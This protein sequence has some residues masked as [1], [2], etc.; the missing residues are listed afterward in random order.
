MESEAAR[1][2]LRVSLSRL[3]R[4]LADRA[5]HGPRK[6]PLLRT[7]DRAFIALN[8][9]RWAPTDVARFE[10]A[11]LR[12]DSA[13]TAGVAAATAGATESLESAALEAAVSVY[14]GPLLPGYDD[15]WVDAERQRLE[16]RYL[17][18]LRRLVRLCVESR[19]FDRAFDYARRALSVD[20]LRQGAHRDLM[21]LHLLTGRPDAALRQLRD[22]ESLLSRSSSGVALSPAT[23]ALGE[24]IAAAQAAGAQPSS[25]DGAQTN[26]SAVPSL[27][28]Q[29]KVTTPP[30]AS[31]LPTSLTRFFGREAEAAE[32]RTILLGEK[33]APSSSPRRRRL[34]SLTGAGGSGKTRLAEVVAQE[35]W[36][37]GRFAGSVWWLAVSDVSAADSLLT[38]LA[39]RVKDVTAAATE[40]PSAARAVATGGEP[41]TPLKL[42]AAA[43]TAL[44]GSTERSEDSSSVAAFTPSEVT[45][46]LLVL[47][48]AETFLEESA[49]LVRELLHLV[50]SLSCLVTSRV[51]LGLHGEQTF[52]ISMLPCGFDELDST[53]I[54]PE[55]SIA[56]TST[57][58]ALMD[59]PAIQLFA[60]RARLVRPQF[61]LTTQNV[62]VVS[63]LCARLDGS[64][65]AIEL[66]AA[67]TRTMTPAQ[68]LARLN[69]DRF[70]LLV[71][72]GRDASERHRSLWSVIESGERLL[73]AE[74]CRLFRQLS[75]FRGGFTM[76]AALA[77]CGADYSAD[78]LMVLC[79]HSLVLARG[80][81]RF[82]LLES[83]REYA[84]ARLSPG[85]R[86]SVQRRH[87]RFC[88][89]VLDG[90]FRDENSGDRDQSIMSRVSLEV[91]NVR[92]AMER[93]STATDIDDV[94]LGLHLAGVR[95]DHWMASG[96]HLEGRA[97][98][99][100]MLRHA[101]AIEQERPGSLP[102][103][104]VWHRAMM[105]SGTLAAMA[106]D[107]EAAE[108]R[109]ARANAIAE[110]V[111]LPLSYLTA[112][113]VSWGVVHEMRGDLAA[114][115]TTYERCIALCTSDADQTP[116]PTHAVALINL[117][118]IHGRLGDYKLAHV[119]VERAYEIACRLE[120]GPTSHNRKRYTALTLCDMGYAETWLGSYAVARRHL[121]ES[122][123]LLEEAGDLS[124]LLRLRCVEAEWTLQGRKDAAEAAIAFQQILSEA[125]ERCDPALILR[126][127]EGLCRARHRSGQHPRHTGV[128]LGALQALIEHY[129]A[130]FTDFETGL[131]RSVRTD[132]EARFGADTTADA[133]ERGYSLT[134][135]EVITYALQPLPE[136]GR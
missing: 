133:W 98:V 120:S 109:Y 99:D 35:L 55:P 56:A 15:S 4:L 87:A 6:E 49:S 29:D 114:A 46:V 105:G 130:R 28:A 78:L 116:I 9:A 30:T 111:G 2:N 39:K 57:S 79:D 24:Q 72:A 17:S 76:S 58:E 59:L 71:S 38:A 63:A 90:T 18:A 132:L 16:E 53:S 65:L 83:I 103:S 88:L 117:G 21:H 125:W 13:R 129:R 37:T 97:R 48:N 102:L 26:V 126:S 136:P 62:H 25:V 81:G 100:R 64:P 101:D 69:A 44:S 60:D 50:P 80:D 93:S 61:T 8:P 113:L 54:R 66:A 34:V 19:Q 32:I 86:L 131:L 92:A 110:A 82:D 45:G 95:W 77:V 7:G 106:A 14:G 12:A 127:L 27:T 40:A 104:S 11:L 134:P 74:A 22:L 119:L 91:D 5:S 94:M 128:L 52:P 10:A 84:D 36:R 96:L 122:R 20:P 51:S 31:G 118:T 41:D 107:L 89:S 115:R 43:L 1:N 33:G 42:V 121:A 3:N 112:T 67:W 85:E 108:A 123:E 47:D 70:G 68:I 23:K 135:E 73:S 124:A 75:V